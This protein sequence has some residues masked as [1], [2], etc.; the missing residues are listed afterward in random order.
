MSYDIISQSIIHYSSYNNPGSN[1]QFTDVQAITDTTNILLPKIIGTT[2]NS[3]GIGGTDILNIIFGSDYSLDCFSQQLTTTELSDTFNIVGSS[4]ITLSD[5][6][7]FFTLTNTTLTL[8]TTAFSS[9]FLCISGGDG[10]GNDDQCDMSAYELPNVTD[11]CLDKNE[12]LTLDPG[13][14]EATYTWSTGETTQTI[15]ITDTGL[16]QVRVTEGN[17]NKRIAI[18]VIEECE[19]EFFVPTAFTPNG[20]GLN[21]DVEFFG[22]EFDSFEFKIFN[23]WGEVMFKSNSKRIK[24]DGTYRNGNAISGTYLWI[25]T[26]SKAGQTKKFNGQIT[27][28]D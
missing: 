11:I 8:E 14:G 23:K 28:L 16:Y 5:T 4:S 19:L 12:I 10:S 6:N 24:W 17:C 27:L 26:C 20:D 21:D 2:T 18:N 9:E 1:D 3:E 22:D 7:D 13:D 15:A 25:A